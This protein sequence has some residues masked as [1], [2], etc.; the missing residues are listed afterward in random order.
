M[1]AIAYGFLKE[2]EIEDMDSGDGGRWMTDT[3]SSPSVMAGASGVATALPTSS[4]GIW[5]RANVKNDVCVVI[6]LLL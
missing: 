1:A 6:H 2:I 5:K 3:G 4:P